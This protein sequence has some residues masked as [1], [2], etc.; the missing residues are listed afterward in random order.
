MKFLKQVVIIPLT[1]KKSTSEFFKL[2]SIEM[3]CE[4]YSGIVISVI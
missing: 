1:G 2:F 4:V 3:Y